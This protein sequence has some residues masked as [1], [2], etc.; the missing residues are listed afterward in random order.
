MNTIQ[1][2]SLVG[3]SA[4]CAIIMLVIFSVSYYMANRYF[5]NRLHNEMQN[6]SKALA[7][8][9]QE[10]VFAYDSA[11]TA[12]I[13]D[14]FVQF[15]HIAAI[16]VLDH[17]DKVIAG[18][19]VNAAPHLSSNRVP[20][21]WGGERVVGHVVIQFDMN[22][23][24]ALLSALALTLLVI[25]VILMFSLQL[26]NWFILTRFVTRP[27][28]LIGA[29]MDEIARG[30]GDLTRRLSVTTNDEIGQL[31]AGF[32]VF[33]S[34]IHKLMVSTSAAAG[35]LEECTAKIKQNTATNAQETQKQLNEISQVSV[36]ISQMT[37]ASQQVAQSAARTSQTTLSSA[38]LAEQGN[39]KVRR[40][41]DEVHSLG[42]K[43]SQTSEKIT[44]LKS[45]SQ[46]ISSVLEV[47]KS[48]AEQTNLLA[49]NAAI[50]AARAGE[51]GR[52]F[53]VVADEVRALAQRTQD[54]TTEI[55]RI[56][57]NLQKSTEEANGLMDTT[58][59]LLSETIAD[60]T[61]AI[62]ALQE[63]IAEFATINEM[64]QQIA[65]AS[66]QQGEVAGD[67]DAKVTS[68]I[69]I[70]NKVSCHAE[71]VERLSEDLDS[72]S[73]DI[74]QELSQFKLA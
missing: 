70:T 40:T 71:S 28:Q 24:A 27:V 49:L 29:A 66:Q 59:A 63:I 56:I 46:D 26:A 43:I 69:T 5:D 14:S 31:A 73:Q 52:G 35:L 67:V 54:S 10:P 32:N 42:D 2:K 15:P 34:H 72:I 39:Q 53:A 9:L 58:R 51:Q 62:G 64:N 20:V 16:Q 48:I 13:L 17:R 57:N 21:L 33:I 36:A 61:H 74:R 41:I 3:L 6:S 8:V 37:V 11:L 7:V 19:L 25:A 65:H 44:D 60:S 12:D 18:E 55:E 22:S 4:L 50:E 30:G 47:I 68:I 1:K 23:N 45:R 38:G